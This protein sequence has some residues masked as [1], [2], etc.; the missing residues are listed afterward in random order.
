MK[1]SSV[2]RYDM[3]KMMWHWCDALE[4]NIK[5]YNSLLSECELSHL[6]LDPVTNIIKDIQEIIR[7]MSIL[8]S[9]RELICCPKNTNR[10]KYVERMEDIVKDFFKMK[11]TY[12]LKWKRY[13]PGIQRLIDFLLSY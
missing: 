13:E 3:M 12:E 10:L 1:Y 4:D 2:E 9:K 6:N 7:D 11:K 8:I 5:C